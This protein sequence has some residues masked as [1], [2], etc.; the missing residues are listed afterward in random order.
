MPSLHITGETIEVG[1]WWKISKA[2]LEGIVNPPVLEA[3]LGVA[4]ARGEG[5]RA[6]RFSLHPVHNLCV[7]AVEDVA[8]GNV[9]GEPIYRPG[10]A[11]A[12]RYGCGLEKGEVGGIES[13]IGEGTGQA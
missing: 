3:D 5:G 1:L 7:F 10:P 13:P 9:V 8:T 12:A 2:I 11:E 4:F 6:T